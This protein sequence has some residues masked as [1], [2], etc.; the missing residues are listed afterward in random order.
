MITEIIKGNILSLHTARIKSA[1]FLA[2]KKQ[3]EAYEATILS[4]SL[5]VRL[6]IPLTISEPI[7]RCL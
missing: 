4:V 5:L 1:D 2:L 3:S 6:C 7:S